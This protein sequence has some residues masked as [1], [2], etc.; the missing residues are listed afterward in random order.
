MS[1]YFLLYVLLNTFIWLPLELYRPSYH[2]KSR[3][4]LNEPNRFNYAVW[5]AKTMLILTILITYSVMNPIMWLLG[6][7]YFVFATFVFSYNLSMSWVPEFE[8]GAKQWPLVFGRLRFGFMISIF[9]LIGYMALKQAYIEAALLLPLAGFVWYFSGNI[10]LK[11]RQVFRAP[12]LTS[13]RDKDAQITKLINKGKENI[14]THLGTKQQ[15]EKAYLPPI[16]CIEYK[17]RSRSPS[18][19]ANESDNKLSV[20]GADDNISG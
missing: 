14:P 11:F 4:G 10:N 13:S 3:F 20:G 16:M 2:F 6:L 19:L 8:T 18:K 15:L 12:S 9:T 17:S 7:I 5:F 1:V